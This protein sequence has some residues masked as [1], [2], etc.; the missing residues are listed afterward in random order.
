MPNPW[1]DIPLEDYEGHMSLPAIG[2]A[3]MLADQLALLIERER[4]T[5][6][7]VVGCAGGNGLDR[8]EPGQM[9]RVVAVDINPA[10]LEAVGIRHTR[11]LTGLELYCADIQSATLQFEPVDMIYAALLFEYVDVGVALASL[12]RHCRP[13]GLLATL[14]QLPHRDHNVVS[15]SP[16]KS[17]NL[18]A[19]VMKLIA[20]AELSRLAMAAGFVA[21]ECDVIELPSGK[22]F[23]LQ[24]F[25]LPPRG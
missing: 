8:I 10:Y 11:R 17:L 12:K 13:G 5:S 19:P 16:Y 22:Q 15:P 24:T 25:R 7:A 6:L 1:L 18:L 3:Q 2:Q 4:P 9:E 14:I 21:A 20:P 23:S